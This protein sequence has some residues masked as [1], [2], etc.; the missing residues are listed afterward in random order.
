MRILVDIP[1]KDLE[2]VNGVAKKL[3]I[4]RAEFVRRAIAF[5][6]EPHRADPASEAF[7]IWRDRP[8]DGLEYQERI[9]G[10]W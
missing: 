9:R 1:A 6:L 3:D 7:G 2:L 4:S 5:Y 10:E 8:V